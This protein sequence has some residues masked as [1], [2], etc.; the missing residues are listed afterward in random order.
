MTTHTLSPL[1]GV[2]WWAGAVDRGLLRP[3][4]PVVWLTYPIAHLAYWL[5]RGP[6]VGAYPYFLIDVDT[7]GY[8]VVAVWTAV[9][10]AG[11]LAL[12]MFMWL[13]DRV[14]H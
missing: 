8:A 7:L 1:L 2:V 3:W 11:F 13:V 5:V 14:R 10:V 9:L 6:I 12:G 4:H